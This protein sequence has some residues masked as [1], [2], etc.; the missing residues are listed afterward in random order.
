MCGVDV[1]F[2]YVAQKPDSYS[3]TGVVFGWMVE[4]QTTSGPIV[5]N[6]ISFL[7]AIAFY[8]FSNQHLDFIHIRAT[9]ASL[10]ARAVCACVCVGFKFSNCIFF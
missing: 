4:L 5:L 1:S 2:F 10:G 8:V 6:L 3:H 7:Q 9:F